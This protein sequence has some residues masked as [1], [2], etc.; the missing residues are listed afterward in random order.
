MTNFTFYW[1][2][3]EQRKKYNKCVNWNYPDEDW[4]NAISFLSDFFAAVSV[5]GSQES[6]IISCRLIESM[7]DLKELGLL[8]R[9]TDWLN[10]WLTKNW[11][12]QM[13]WWIQFTTV[14]STQRNPD[15]SSVSPSSEFSLRPRLQGSRQIFERT[16]T[17]TDLP[18]VY[19][20]PTEPC[21]FLNGAS[22]W[23]DQK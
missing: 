22:F 18:F 7:T 20:E 4:K 3:N 5:L 13:G 21:K 19:T 8:D 1:V 12:C 11:F 17:C 23:L 6:I 16:K 9:L 2:V 10:D 14:K 15:V